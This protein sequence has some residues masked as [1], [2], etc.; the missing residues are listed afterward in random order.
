[1]NFKRVVVDDE[2]TFMADVD[3]YLRTGYGALGWFA[4]KWTAD[5]LRPIG[6]DPTIIDELWLDHDLGSE[7]AVMPL[8]DFLYVVARYNVITDH[9]SLAIGKIFVHS[10]NSVGSNNI[11]STL[12]SCYDVE[13]VALPALSSQKQSQGE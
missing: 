13:R 10:M 3:I 11:V 9:G 8:V 5:E 7:I 6:A 1:M 12:R 4:A 2:R